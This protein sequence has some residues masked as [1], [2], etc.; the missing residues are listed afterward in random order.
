MYEVRRLFP[1]VTFRMITG[2]DTPAPITIVNGEYATSRTGFTSNPGLV[3]NGDY[4]YV[5]HV[6][7]AAF[8]T[9]TTT[10][11]TIGGVSAEFSTHTLKRSVLT[12]GR[13][14]D[15]NGDGYPDM[16]WRNEAAGDT[17]VWLLDDTFP[18][19]GWFLEGRTL[20]YRRLDWTPTHF[21]DFDGDGTTDIVWR[22]AT[23]GETA[24]WLITDGSM[25]EGSIVMTDAA[26]TVTHVADF[27]GDGT[28]DLIWHHAP[29]GTTSMWLMNGLQMHAGATLVADPNWR[30]ALTCDL[31]GDG[32]SDIVW[33]SPTLGNAAWLV[34][35]TALTAGAMLAA[36]GSY[37]PTLAP[38]LDRD[39]KDDLVW[40]RASTYHAF[41][42]L[43]DG[44]VMKTGS[45]LT[46]LSVP[47]ATGHVDED[48]K[49][50]LFYKRL[51]GSVDWVGYDGLRPIHGGSSLSPTQ[52]SRGFADF[53]GNGLVDDAYLESATAT[54]STWVVYRLPAS[55]NY[56][57]LKPPLLLLASPDWR[58]L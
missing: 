26:W 47:L 13:F 5:R 49:A 44:L 15:F 45:N 50:D 4:V 54:P 48:G 11:V 55:T 17:A 25:R 58:L 16:I 27:D 36:D 3:V 42:W 21:G 40:F 28:S 34:N 29:S 46:Q 7:S 10:T 41:G 19:T 20:L 43:M 37:D 57:S 33:H 32:R 6:A 31:N 8:G 51:D 24:L 1:A 52:A 23:T 12:S 14:R 2:I 39:G 56:P 35:G 53:D 9:T 18:T 38:D 22:N 30:V